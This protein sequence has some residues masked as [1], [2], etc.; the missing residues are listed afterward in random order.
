MSTKAIKPFSEGLIAL[1]TGKRAIVLKFL[2]KEFD[3]WP[4]PTKPEPRTLL[5]G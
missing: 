5:Q 4:H 3:K 1:E 2:R